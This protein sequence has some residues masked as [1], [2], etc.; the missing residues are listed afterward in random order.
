M[1]LKSHETIFRGVFIF[2]FLCTFKQ[3]SM[4]FDSNPPDESQKKKNLRKVKPNQAN[5]NMKKVVIP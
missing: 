3:Q 1:C 2:F 4:D 5:Q